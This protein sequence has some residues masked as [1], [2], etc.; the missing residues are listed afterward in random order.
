MESFVIFILGINLRD[1]RWLVVSIYG[2]CNKIIRLKIGKP[3]AL[4]KPIAGIGQGTSVPTPKLADGED[5]VCVWVG[6][7]WMSMAV[8]MEDHRSK[9]KIMKPTSWHINSFVG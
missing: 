1:Q 8:A 3:A 4:P 9:D 6:L 7:R 2:G 5:S